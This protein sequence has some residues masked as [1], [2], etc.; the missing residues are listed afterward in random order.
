[1]AEDN[2]P[3]RVAGIEMDGMAGVEFDEMNC[4]ICLEPVDDRCVLPRCF[5]AC[6]CFACILEWIR[7]KSGEKTCPLCVTPLGA[8]ILHGLDPAANNFLMHQVGGDIVAAD[9]VAQQHAQAESPATDTELSVSPE[10]GI[11]LTSAP[12]H[13]R[14]ARSAEEV[15]LSEEVRH[16]Y[17][18]RRALQHRRNVYRHKLFA[19][20][21]A[22][23]RWTKY[24]PY[25]GPSGFRTQPS[26]ARLLALFLSRELQ[27][28]PHLDVPFLS[29]Y[30]PALLSHGDVRSDTLLDRLTEWIGN[31][32]DA[33][34]LAHEME[35]FVRS[36]RGGLGLD[37]YDSCPWLQYDLVGARS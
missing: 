17:K 31:R 22:S 33:E 23:N 26:Y 7:T 2:V 14:A 9:G 1:M 5:H 30:I 28:W 29:S 11:S 4:S 24:K 3:D 18:M 34:L 36:G 19:K 10:L 37:Q 20:H 27:V 15:R 16:R 6:F 32:A 8:Y 13:C 21:V 25:P 12:I 35:L